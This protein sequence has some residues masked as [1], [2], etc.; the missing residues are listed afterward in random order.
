MNNLSMEQSKKFY[1]PSN[2]AE[3]ATPN[4]GIGKCLMILREGMGM[5]PYQAANYCGVSSVKLSDWE[6]DDC[7]PTP[8]QLET[9]ARLYETSVENILMGM[10]CLEELKLNREHRA[11]YQISLKPG[12]IAELQINKNAQVMRLDKSDIQELGQF[13]VEADV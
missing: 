1:K 8:E 5:A 13:L 10:E 3:R 7:L 6:K 9:L 2:S 12:G 11:E 4:Q